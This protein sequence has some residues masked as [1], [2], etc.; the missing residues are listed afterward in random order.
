MFNI[1]KKKGKESNND[2]INK[3]TDYCQD[4]GLTQ[5]Q[6]LGLAYFNSAIPT[7]LSF[8]NQNEEILKPLAKV[9]KDIEKISSKEANAL[10]LYR[11]FYFNSKSRGKSIFPIEL[12]NLPQDF[13]EGHNK[14]LKHDGPDTGMLMN[15]RLTILLIYELGVCEWEV[16]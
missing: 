16:I 1:F 15:S 4:L 6:I 9:V 5:V 7:V 12:D 13:F 2:L 14:Y 8:V 10:Y 3:W 11:E